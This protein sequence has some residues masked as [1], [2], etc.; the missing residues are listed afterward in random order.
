MQ[1]RTHTFCA[2]THVGEH[3]FYLQAAGCPP[4]FHLL[5]PPPPEADLDPDDQ[6]TFRAHLPRLSVS[7]SFSLFIRSSNFLTC[8]PS[9]CFLSSL[10]SSLPFLFLPLSLLSLS[11]LFPF[12]HNSSQCLDR[13]KARAALFKCPEISFQGD[14]LWLP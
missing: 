14:R 7:L 12:S 13:L 10:P 4:P 9:C 11:L 3:L 8:P 2:F 6:K 1:A 5:L